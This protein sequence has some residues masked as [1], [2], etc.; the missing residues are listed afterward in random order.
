M[1][2]CPRE[3]S[4]LTPTAWISADAAGVQIDFQS[5]LTSCKDIGCGV[6]VLDQSHRSC[7]SLAGLGTAL[8]EQQFSDSQPR[9]LH[10]STTFC[11][12]E[13]MLGALPIRI[14]IPTW[15]M[16][17]LDFSRKEKS[18]ARSVPSGGTATSAPDCVLW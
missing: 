15:L 3:G 5:E 17:A 13:V 4:A 16:C 1:E 7:C 11:W 18:S 9:S 14:Q 8:G 12:A 10:A 6:M 2:T